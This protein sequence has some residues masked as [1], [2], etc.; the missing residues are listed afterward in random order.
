MN[1]FNLFSFFLHD[2]KS[3][4]KKKLRIKNVSLILGGKFRD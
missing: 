3:N 1:S 2:K 4:N